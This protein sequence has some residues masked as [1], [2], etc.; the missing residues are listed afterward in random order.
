MKSS[1]LIRHIVIQKERL[2]AF[3][4]YTELNKNSWSNEMLKKANTY[5]RE[6]VESIRK[7]EIILHTETFG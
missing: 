2:K 4:S 7:M 6:V 5:R 3:V 1:S